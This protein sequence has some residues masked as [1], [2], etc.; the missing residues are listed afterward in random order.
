MYGR[1]LK[2]PQIGPRLR[3]VL[4]LAAAAAVLAFLFSR[5]DWQRSWALIRGAEPLLLATVVLIQMGDR[6]LM[7]LKWRQL[8]RVLD[9]RLSSWASIRVYYESTFIGFAL[10]LGGLGPDV[11]RFARLRSHGVDPHIT[12]ASIIME[13]LNG[14]VATFAL[15]AA[16]FAVLT[17]LAPQ[18]ALRNFAVIAAIGAG[19]AGLLVAA[20]IFYPPLARSLLRLFRLPTP[21][22]GSRLA[23]YVEAANAYSARRATLA[24]NLALSLIEQTASVFTMWVSSHAIGAPLPWIV[25]FAVTPV[26]VIIQR[27][28]LTYA[29]LGLREG[30]AAALLVALGYDYSAALT[31]LMTTFVMFLIALMP[32]AIILATQGRPPTR[33]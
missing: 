7:A 31:L 22:E 1:Y 10:P 6:V 33:E 14:V 30:S 24:G 19:V 16:G 13:R 2:L 5:L 23:K 17:Q 27:L 9:P 11:V 12:L 26:A 25:C 21:G 20:L 32:G 18:P 8:L 29:G 4:Q 28:P 15:I 3:L